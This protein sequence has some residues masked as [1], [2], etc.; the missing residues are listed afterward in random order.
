VNVS[1]ARAVDA[2]NFFLRA[3]AD[4]PAQSWEQPSNLDGWSVRDLVAHTTGT[5]AKV[6]AL[7]GGDASPTDDL[8]QLADRLSEA[9][10]KG[11]PDATLNFPVVGLTIHAW[12]IYRSSHQPVAVPADLLAFCREVVDAVPEDELRR[13]GMFGPAQPVPEDATPTTRFMAFVGRPA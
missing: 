2:M 5:A 11:E 1:G 9:L 12:D 8:H 7:A 3:V 13:P 10:G 4:I 6:V